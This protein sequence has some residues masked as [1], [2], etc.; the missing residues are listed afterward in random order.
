MTILQRALEFLK[1]GI[2]VIPLWHRSKG[3]MMSWERY[4]TILSTE[5]QVFNWLASG[6]NNYGV[7]TGWRGLTVID[8]DDFYTFGLWKSYMELMKLPMPYTVLSSRGAHV[9]ISTTG[10]S[11]QKR[12]GVDVK[13]H[14]YVVG[15]GS[16]HPNGTQYVAVNELRLMPVESLETILPEELFPHVAPVTCF[17]GVAAVITPNTE[18]QF[19]P[20]ASA[21]MDLISKVKAKV[22]IENFFKD[23]EK[24]SVNGKWYSALC[25]FHDDHNPSLWI[26]T[27]KQICGCNVCNFKPKDVIN[28]YALQHNIPESAAVTMMAREVGVWA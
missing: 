16:T 25:P 27:E 11:N 4:N 18:Y 15:P 26:N 14:G 28:L 24:T 3:P 22:R 17:N 23:A 13:F 1:L 12:R 6:W 21:G 2:S 7:V 8:F 9:Y 20:F 10:G 19:D 5:W